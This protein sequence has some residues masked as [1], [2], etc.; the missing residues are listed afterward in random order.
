LE[1][2]GGADSGDVKALVIDAMRGDRR[3]NW[4]QM[5]DGCVDGDAAQY[6]ALH[7]MPM[8]EV[9]PRIV[10]WIEGI[11]RSQADRRKAER[12]RNR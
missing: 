5:L 10:R 11:E 4:R 12:K 9:L 8:T 3:T 2:T 6:A 1:R 7:Q